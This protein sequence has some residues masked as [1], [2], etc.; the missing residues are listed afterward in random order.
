MNAL[1]A[2]AVLASAAQ[3]KLTIEAPEKILR[4]G[5]PMLVRCTIENVGSSEA[6][7]DEPE[8]Y[9]EGFEIRDFEDRIVKA[10]GRTRGITR[11]SPVVDP[12]GFFG[13]TVDLSGAFAVPE[14]RE[15]WYRLRWSF[16]DQV[17]NELRVL[18]LRDWVASIE[19]NHG[20]IAIEFFPDVAPNHVLN[21]V[22]LA[23]SGFYEGSIFHRIIPGFMMQGGA[24]RDPKNEL[25]TPLQAEFS[26][27]KHVF[28]TVSAARTNDPHSATSQFF[29]CFAPAPHLDG[30]YSVFGRVVEGADVVK[31]I[32]KVKT[33]H[34]PCKGCGAVAPRPGPTRC[35]GSH[36]QDR[37]EADVVIKKVTLS[38]RKKGKE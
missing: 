11:R 27:R 6:R 28:G 30:Q 20:S 37:P 18:V 38:E 2:A 34:S 10:T 32:E 5:R 33:D 8:D 26:D 13:R 12:G 19:T 3:V 14:D 24:P 25:K 16:G 35:C 4:P 29:I 31:E 15:G 9:L 23:R 22:R 36:H 21:F 17:S 1:L 7:L